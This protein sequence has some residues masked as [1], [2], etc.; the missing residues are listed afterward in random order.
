MPVMAIGHT[1]ILSAYMSL[2]TR[3]DVSHLKRE[4][5]SF[6]A[7]VLHATR[8][9]CPAQATLGTLSWQYLCT[10][11][12]SSRAPSALGRLPCI[13]HQKAR[14]GESLISFV[15]LSADRLCYATQD[16]VQAAQVHLPQLLQAQDAAGRG[17]SAHIWPT[18][19]KLQT[20]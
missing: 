2:C 14:V 4:I 3:H 11:L 17:K 10:T 16:N 5:V 18:H 7:G 9:T 20:T 6:V 13:C 19:L 15:P 1:T 8:A 12:S